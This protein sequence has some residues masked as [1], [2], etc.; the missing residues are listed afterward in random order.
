MSIFCC[1][2][3][4]FWLLRLI[5][6]LTYLL[7]YLHPY[8]R[9]VHLSVSLSWVAGIDSKLINVRF[10]ASGSTVTLNFIPTMVVGIICP[11]G[12]WKKYG[13]LE[14]NRLI[15][16]L[17]ELSRKVNKFGLELAV[18]TTIMQLKFG[19]L[20]TISAELLNRNWNDCQREWC[21]CRFYL[22]SATQYADAR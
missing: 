11:S 4:L 6:T 2:S 15:F 12:I 20:Q 13:W 1:A 21:T 18:N 17:A 16:G 5:N 14:K 7:T 8:E 22:A 19:W 9:R 3:W 10:S